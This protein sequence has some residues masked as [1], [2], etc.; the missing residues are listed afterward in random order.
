MVDES[1]SYWNT[2]NASIDIFLY[3]STSIG[4]VASYL[5]HDVKIVCTIKY[6]II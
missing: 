4:D 2:I 5:Y 3:Q 6:Y 1:V